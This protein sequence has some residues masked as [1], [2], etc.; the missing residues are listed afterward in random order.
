MATI[1]KNLV[2]TILNIFYNIDMKSFPLF[3]Y[4]IHIRGNNKC[5]F[6]MTQIAISFYHSWLLSLF[7]W[8]K[9][10][11]SPLFF[12]TCSKWLYNVWIPM[13]THSNISPFWN[14][15]SSVST[16]LGFVRKEIIEIV[17]IK[18]RNYS[19]TLHVLK[20]LKVNSNM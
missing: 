10:A 2:V 14:W 8:Q 15:Y 6:W 5:L 1:E 12:W 4:I 16:H 3:F 18:E 19:K 20:S 9:E 17:E 7:R 11:I 13:S